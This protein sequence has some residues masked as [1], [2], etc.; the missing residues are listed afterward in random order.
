[1]IHWFK[2]LFAT[3]TVTPRREDY[4]DVLKDIERLTKV[5]QN[6]NMECFDWQLIPCEFKRDYK[7]TDGSLYRVTNHGFYAIMYMAKKKNEKTSH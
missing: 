3:K 7:E 2:K 5:Y 4:D 6:V 1:M